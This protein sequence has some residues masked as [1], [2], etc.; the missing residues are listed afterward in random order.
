GAIHAC[1]R[2][3]ADHGGTY[4]P[5][6]P[7]RKSVAASRV[8]SC[9]SVVAARHPEKY[10]GFAGTDGSS[11]EAYVLRWRERRRQSANDCTTDALSLERLAR[12][13]DGF[14]SGDRGN[15]GPGSP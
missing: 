13:S 2:S 15:G 12:G 6:V 7:G 5:V 3:K 8:L 11:A 9:G 14:R 4:E 10:A 1:Y